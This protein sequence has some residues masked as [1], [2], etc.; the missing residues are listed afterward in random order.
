VRAEDHPCLG[1]GEADLDEPPLCNSAALADL[2]T[3]RVYEHRRAGWTATEELANALTSPI[4]ELAEFTPAQ[5]AAHRLHCRHVEV[6]FEAQ[7]SG[8]AEPPGFTLRWCPG[9]VE[10]C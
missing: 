10:G 3:Y 7:A 5:H 4:P 1:C 8:G 9:Y 2:D 6:F